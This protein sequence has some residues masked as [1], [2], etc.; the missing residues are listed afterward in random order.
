MPWLH[1]HSAFSSV[2][3]LA[4]YRQSFRSTHTCSYIHT[5]IHVRQYQP[6]KVRL[7][8]YGRERR[9]QITRSA[10]GSDASQ[11]H[12]IDGCPLQLTCASIGMEGQEGGG[13]RGGERARYAHLDRGCT[14]PD[15]LS[16]F[17]SLPPPHAKERTIFTRW[18]MLHPSGVGR[19]I[20]RP[21]ANHA[22]DVTPTTRRDLARNSMCG[23]HMRIDVVRRDAFTSP[24]RN[25]DG[26]ASSIEASARGKASAGEWDV[27][28]LMGFVV[29]AITRLRE[30]HMW[31]CNEL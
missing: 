29:D 3:S 24:R 13:G 4:F 12:T 31:T 30:L 2:C 27:I 25:D 7:R 16:S 22:V 26:V 19:D 8:T 9:A 6:I 23:V 17:S 20:S 1:V 10:S 11:E 15:A 21:Y 18:W 14:R 28:G 5:C